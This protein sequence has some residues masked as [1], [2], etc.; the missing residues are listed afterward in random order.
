MLP[1]VSGTSTLLF[2][3]AHKSAVATHWLVR[4]EGGCTARWLGNE[5]EDIS[6]GHGLL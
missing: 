2:L 1:A 6:Q 4:D 5:V 3:F